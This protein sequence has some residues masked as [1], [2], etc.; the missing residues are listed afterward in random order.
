M[1]I[2]TTISRKMVCKKCKTPYLSIDDS[3]CPVCSKVNK[4]LAV[5]REANRKQRQAVSGE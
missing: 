1:K 2:S 3:K 5:K 4:E